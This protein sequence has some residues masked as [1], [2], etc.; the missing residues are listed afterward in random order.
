MKAITRYLFLTLLT[1]LVSPGGLL[2]DESQRGG[3]G[4]VDY[5]VL[6]LYVL[7]TI[8][9]GYFI[10]KRQ[11][12]REEYFTGG[13]NMN[14]ILIGV[15]LFA[16]LLSTISYLGMPGE[17]AGK[18]PVHFVGL[19]GYPLIFII[20]AMVMLPT[21]MN[22]RVT[23]AYEL[24]EDKL[25]VGFR[26]LGGIMFLAL[27]LIWMAVLLK[28]AGD[29]MI[30]MLDI[31]QSW[32]LLVVASIGLVAIIYTSLGGLQ[33][34]VITDVMQTILLYGG[35]V[36]VL[37][38]ITID[39][40]GFGWIPSEWPAEW[41][42]Q[43]I[44]PSS[45]ETRVSWFGSIL[46]GVIWYVATLG[47]DQTTVQR[48]MATKDAAGAR[49]AVLWQLG[50]SVVVGITLCFV[51]I[52]LMAHY[53]NI[54]PDVPI[55]ASGTVEEY[56]AFKEVFSNNHEKMPE[57]DDIVHFLSWSEKDANAIFRYNTRL[58]LQADQFFPH[59]IANGLPTGLTGLVIAAMFAAAM[60]SLDSG[61]NS[62]TAVV[63]TDFI[64]RF[65]KSEMTEKQQLLTAR[66]IAV[67][68][69]V[70]VVFGSALTEFIQGNI[71]EVTASAVNLLTTPIF[72]LFIYALYFKRPNR[73]IVGC[74]T[75]IGVATALYLAFGD[76]WG[77]HAIS[78]QWIGPFALTA[79]LGVGVALHGILKLGG[80]R[81]PP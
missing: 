30:T 41:D 46:T 43:P 19:I 16:T 53:K 22:H 8:F 27:R 24:L 60:S 59:F 64:E 45:L 73:A 9:L 11:K 29:A 74:A 77:W 17:A 4:V 78:F 71:M 76:E 34:V 55:L 81:T 7:G 6:G 5:G 3:V 79:N 33:A 20:F 68:V 52:A 26:L 23:S 44:F 42:P 65:R 37:I 32:S 14:S 75:L 63:S 48:F 36:T 40:G 58:Q 66:F 38:I 47:S 54:E 70:I 67:L 56:Q 35:A 69:G 18:G 13:G 28:A 15:S 2:A 12:S 57:P 49:T 72:G 61:V 80:K 21:Y 62:I 51:G 10:S 1:V 31:D 39:F 25:G 50:V